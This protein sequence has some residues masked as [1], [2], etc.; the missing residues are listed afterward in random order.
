MNDLIDQL[1]L[2]QVALPLMRHRIERTCSGGVPSRVG[3]ADHGDIGVAPIFG[4]GWNLALSA[5]VD[6]LCFDGATRAA[7]RAALAEVAS[8]RTLQPITMPAPSIRTAIF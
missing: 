1:V 7:E 2:L 4:N 3:S 5:M 6:A 8:T